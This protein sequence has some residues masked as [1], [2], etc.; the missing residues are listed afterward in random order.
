VIEIHEDPDDRW[1]ESAI[2]A[3]LAQ[4]G[5]RIDRLAGESGGMP[6]L[7]AVPPAG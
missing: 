2:R 3:E 4:L 6:H 5:Y 7:L 1:R